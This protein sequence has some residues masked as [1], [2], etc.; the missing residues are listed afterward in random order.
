MSQSSP[1]G[2]NLSKGST[3]VSAELSINEE[4]VL[5]VKQ[6]NPKQETLE[7]AAEVYSKR[8]SAS[9]FQEN[10][11]KDFI[12]GAKWQQDKLKS[13]VVKWRQ[14][15]LHY[16]EVAEDNIAS[17]HNHRKFTYKAM[18]TRDCWK[19]LLKLIEDEK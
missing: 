16:E 5:S 19:E 6:E 14:L 10:H 7:E 18:A 15:Q 8:S 17:E 9:V 3:L 13:L 12:N 1:E 11:K 4:K 2:I